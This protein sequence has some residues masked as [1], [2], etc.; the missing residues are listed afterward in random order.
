MLAI[1]RDLYKRF[2]LAG[3]VYPQG[4]DHVRKK[5]KAGKIVNFNCKEVPTKISSCTFD[6]SSP[7]CGNKCVFPQSSF[8]IES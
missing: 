5:A 4:L 6:L 1:I 7:N 3:R 2:L 8:L